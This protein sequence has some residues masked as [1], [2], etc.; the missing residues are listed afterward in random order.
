MKE[1]EKKQ[2][3]CAT[4]LGCWDQIELTDVDTIVLFVFSC[5]WN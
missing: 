3:T 2:G 4:E 5:E 1:L